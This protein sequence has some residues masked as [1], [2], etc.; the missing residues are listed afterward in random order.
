MCAAIGFARPAIEGN[1]FSCVI[2]KV[3]DKLGG[4]GNK[5]IS[6]KSICCRN[7]KENDVLLSLDANTKSFYPEYGPSDDDLD[8]LSII[9]KNVVVRY[10]I[11]AFWSL[12]KM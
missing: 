10:R 8:E 1:S 12:E 7:V 2:T 3:Y 5:A 6:K 9:P 4:T 11:D